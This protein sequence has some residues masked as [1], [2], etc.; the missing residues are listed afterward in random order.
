MAKTNFRK[1]ETTRNHRHQNVLVTQT[2]VKSL[3]KLFIYKTI[4][5]PIWTYGIQLWGTASISNIEILECFQPKALRIA[6]THLGT[7]R[8]WLSEGIS[9]HQQLKKKSA[10]TALNTVLATRGLGPISYRG[11]L[12]STL[13]HAIVYIF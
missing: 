4:L 5:N 12:L 9:I 3:H 10:A 13:L 11:A 2:Q 7:C 6:W 8:I 1:T